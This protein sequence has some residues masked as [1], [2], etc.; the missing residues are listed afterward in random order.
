VGAQTEAGQASAATGKF[1]EH[2]PVRSMNAASLELRIPA[3]I[4]RPDLDL[5]RSVT[6]ISI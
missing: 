4:G 3:F 6:K 5:E 2:P 1:I